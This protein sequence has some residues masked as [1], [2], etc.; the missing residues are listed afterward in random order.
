LLLIGAELCAK[1]SAI[2]FFTKCPNRS[3]LVILLRRPFDDAVVG[4]EDAG[5]SF[6]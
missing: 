3:A 4:A 1:R 6:S 2:F 5:G